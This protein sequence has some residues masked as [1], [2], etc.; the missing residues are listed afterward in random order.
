[1]KVRAWE[2]GNLVHGRHVFDIAHLDQSE[3]L[4][5]EAYGVRNFGR[6]FGLVLWSWWRGATEKYE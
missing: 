1:M 4:K 2:L 6:C 3:K 5:E